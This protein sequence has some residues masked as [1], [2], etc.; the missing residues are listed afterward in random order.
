MPSSPAATESTS[1][2]IVTAFGSMR[3]TTAVGREFHKKRGYISFVAVEEEGHWLLFQSMDSNECYKLKLP[4]ISKWMEP[5][6]RKLYKESLLVDNCR[7]RAVLLPFNESDL[8]QVQLCFAVETNAYGVV[9]QDHG[10]LIQLAMTR[11][12]KGEEW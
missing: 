9:T 4:S 1:V 10:K 7:L 2:K 11:V 8:L 3:W 12:F 5:S 6:S